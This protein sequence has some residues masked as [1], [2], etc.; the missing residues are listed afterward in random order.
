MRAVRE[1]PGVARTGTAD[2]VLEIEQN[3]GNVTG[4]VGVAEALC[5]GSPEVGHHEPGDSR[6]ARYA[7]G[8]LQKALG[9]HCRQQARVVVH[10]VG[11]DRPV[12]EARQQLRERQVADPHLVR[13]GRLD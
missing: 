13:I 5:D 4:R 3:P 8:D 12:A 2:G 9:S 10:E 6:P 1:E 11:G 7:V